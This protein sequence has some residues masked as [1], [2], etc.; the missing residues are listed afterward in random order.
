RI[1]FHVTDQKIRE[2]THDVRRHH[3]VAKD[4]KKDSTEEEEAPSFLSQEEP[5]CAREIEK[6][7][8]FGAPD[9]CHNAPLYKGGTTGEGLEINSAA[10]R[11][12]LLRFVCVGL[13]SSGV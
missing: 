5:E 13:Y 6:G 8:M 3:R 12:R 2:Q 11:G 10:R 4:S 9:R 1:G 7:K